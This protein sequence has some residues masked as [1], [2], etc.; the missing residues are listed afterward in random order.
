MTKSAEDAEGQLPTESQPGENDSQAGDGTNQD[1]NQIADGETGES[2]ATPT[3]ITGIFLH[4]GS[5]SQTND[6]ARVGCSMADWDLAPQVNDEVGRQDVSWSFVPEARFKFQ[7]KITIPEEGSKDDGFDVIL[8]VKPIDPDDL[9]KINNLT[10]EAQIPGKA[11][12]VKYSTPLDKSNSDMTLTKL[13]EASKSDSKFSSSTSPLIPRTPP[14]YIIEYTAAV[15]GVFMEPDMTNGV[16]PYEIRSFQFRLNTGRFSY[17]SEAKNHYGA[18]SSL[19]NPEQSK[20]LVSAYS[21]MEFDPF[22]NQQ[23][24]FL[25]L[26]ETVNRPAMWSINGIFGSFRDYLEYEPQ[27]GCVTEEAGIVS[28][29][30]RMLNRVATIVTKHRD[31]LNSP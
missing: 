31:S 7:S 9:G 8:E 4:C 10:I 23:E 22:E 5:I 29:T 1:Y 15:S 17:F 25:P 21:R 20:S 6:S 11:K 2:A 24:D 12:A 3:N 26:C 16:S 28:K 30:R 14:F 27:A 18:Y 19:L 13:A